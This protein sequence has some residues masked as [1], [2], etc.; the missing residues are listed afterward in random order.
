MGLLYKPKEEQT[1]SLEIEQEDGFIILEF[2]SDCGK[3]GTDEP[4][5]G[6][7]FTPKRLLE[8]IQSFDD[9]NEL[10]DEEYN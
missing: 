9:Y 8:I 10:K 3:F 6:Y 2:S 7:K 1:T 4:L 5:A